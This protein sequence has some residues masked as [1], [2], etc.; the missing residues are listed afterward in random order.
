MTKQEVV[1]VF[2]D[3]T[4]APLK[5]QRVYKDGKGKGHIRGGLPV[6]WGVD[7]WIYYA[8]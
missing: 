3:G 2:P 7:K 1:M 8:R 5:D 4:E 6:E